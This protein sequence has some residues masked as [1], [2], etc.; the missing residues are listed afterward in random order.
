M[1][2]KVNNVIKY[3]SESLCLRIKVIMV[4]IRAW[5][6]GNYKVIRRHYDLKE[7]KEGQGWMKSK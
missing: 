1:F 3:P 6:H 4:I 2:I 5:K 7:R